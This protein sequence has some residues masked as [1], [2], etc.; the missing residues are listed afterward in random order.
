MTININFS[1]PMTTSVSLGK[2]GEHNSTVLFV[3]SDMSTEGITNYRLAFQTGGQAY[4][5]ESYSELPISYSLPRQLTM[6]PRI[7]IQLIGYDSN[8]ELVR[9]SDKFSKFYFEP[10]V[11]GAEVEVDGNNH[12]L[13]SEIVSVRESLTDISAAI[14]NKA[15]KGESYTKDEENALLYL[16]ASREWVENQ[17]YARASDIP[18]VSN[19]VTKA[20]LITKQDILEAGANIKIEGNVISATGGEGG[21]ELF[22][23]IY[24]ETPYEEIRQAIVDGRTVYGLMDKNIYIYVGHNRGDPYDVAPDK[25]NYIFRFVGL[26]GKTSGDFT[27]YYFDVRYTR[28]ATNYNDSESKIIN[29]NQIAHYYDK[30]AEYGDED[31]FTANA[32]LDAIDYKIQK[33]LENIPSGD[34]PTDK[35]LRF[36]IRDDFNVY[37]YDITNGN[38][39]A[40]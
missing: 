10:S 4:L 26:N 14:A 9:K 12:D 16:K 30:D 8:G 15:D 5:S 40:I 34:T 27:S 7:S 33:A 17:N 28:G 25:T 2:L 31:I 3:S 21:K 1:E 18:D 20:E 29:D 6:Y 35:T 11:S 24:E 36:H 32:V 13:A 19:L 38:E 23:V 39:V 22:W 37:G